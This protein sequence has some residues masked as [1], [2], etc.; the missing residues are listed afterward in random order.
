MPQWA[1]TETTG[2]GRLG[3]APCEAARPERPRDVTSAMAARDAESLIAVGAMRSYGDAA[4]NTDGR[5]VLMTRMDR[6]VELDHD[7]AVVIVESGVTFRELIDTVLPHGLMVPVAPG[8]GYATLGGGL[9]ND[10]HGKNQHRAGCIGDHVDWFDLITP[11]GETRRVSAGNDAEL[12]AATIGGIGLTG[13]IDRICLRLARIPSNA[14]DVAKTRITDLDDFLAQLRAANERS[15]Y[16]VGWIDA[17]A[18]GRKLGRGVLEE[19]SPSQYGAEFT[20]KKKPGPPIDLPSFALNPLSIRAFNDLYYAQTPK[21]GARAHLDYRQFMFPLDAV[22]N[23]NRIYGKRGFRQFQCV[24]PFDTAPDALRA[25]LEKTGKAGR[26]SFLAVLKSM[27][28]AGAGY[29]SFAMEG[30]TLAL[31]FPNGPGADEFIR[32][33]ERMALDAGGR[34]Y[35]AKDSTLSPET[36]AA[37]YPKLSRLR[38]VLGRIDPAGAMSSDMARRLDIR[39]RA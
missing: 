37:M 16:V 7:N 35:L 22:A 10:V 39:G 32:E 26:G 17:L 9:A 12:F 29:L 6:I 36:F 8:T 1:T 30:F 13:I 25:M 19:A 2:W 18:R 24:I 23:W 3:A 38:E 14:V 5:A 34:T 28:P 15:E 20:D 4:M 31:D 33:L 21:A 27:G 11:D